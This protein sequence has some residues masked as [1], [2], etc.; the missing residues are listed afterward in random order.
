MIYFIWHE[1]KKKGESRNFILKIIHVISVL[2][3]FR[4]HWVTS[5]QRKKNVLKIIY[6]SMLIT[7]K[8]QFTIYLNFMEA[9]VSTKFSWCP[10]MSLLSWFWPG[11]MET[12]HTLAFWFPRFEI[13][14]FNLLSPWKCIPNNKQEHR[15]SLAISCVPMKLWPWGK[16]FL[17]EMAPTQAILFFTLKFQLS[18]FGDLFIYLLISFLPSLLC[19]AS[20][21]FQ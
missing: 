6:E 12:S 21:H 1:K 11:P 7:F 10:F 16:G 14:K 9:A 18:C 19:A 8:Y 3:N 15:K 5:S 13:C 20:N 2:I 4:Q 17:G